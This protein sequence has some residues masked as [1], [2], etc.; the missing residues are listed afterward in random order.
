MPLVN[1]GGFDSLKRPIPLGAHA[2][3]GFELT[4][5]TEGKVS[6]KLKNGKDLCLTGG[7]AAI[8]QPNVFH[9]G[10]LNI[11]KPCKLFWLVFEPLAKDALKYTPLSQKALHE[12]N[13]LLNDSGNAI[14]DVNEALAFYFEQFLQILIAFKEG[15]N[16]ELF[17]ASGRAVVCQIFLETAQV[18]SSRQID[19][20]ASTIDMEARNYI[21]KNIC[22][23]ISAAEL[24][25]YFGLSPARFND[26]FKA[27]TGQT[28][29]DF[30]RRIKCSK[31]QE[32][33]AETKRPITEIA[34]DLGFS[35]S[36]YFASVFKKYTGM[37]PGQF[38][39]KR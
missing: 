36:Q 13:R 20:K 6:W 16:D 4:Y 7:Q 9:R 10:E 37:T 17:A 23:D 31:A 32:M 27:D 39:K 24:A 34:F 8:V 5:L 21:E 15:R 11:I 14:R 33:L 38:R 22:S 12:I 30:I 35:S 2:H 1:G 3:K 29:A 25:E 18:F 26:R 28:P 19:R